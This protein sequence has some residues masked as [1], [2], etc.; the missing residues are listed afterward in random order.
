MSDE[1]V[2]DGVDGR[3]YTGFE[4]LAGVRPVGQSSQGSAKDLTGT[5][6]RTNDHLCGYCVRHHA[7]ASSGCEERQS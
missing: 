7:G 3:S 5:K 2:A 4:Y 6:V 1:V